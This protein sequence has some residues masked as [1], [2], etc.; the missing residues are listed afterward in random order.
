MNDL[1]LIIKSCCEWLDKNK[2]WLFS[3]V[4]ITIIAYFISF[5][6]KKN[7][8]NKKNIEITKENNFSLNTGQFTINKTNNN[9]YNTIDKLEK[10]DNKYKN[11]IL[12]ENELKLHFFDDYNKYQIKNF[13]NADPF[14]VYM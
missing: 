7:D 8:S 13:I 4:G 3:G 14:V 6:K 9:Y 10:N 11:L 2:Q 12:D 1:T 5:F